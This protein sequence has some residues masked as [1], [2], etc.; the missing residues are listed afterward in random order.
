MNAIT[1][2]YAAHGTKL[3]GVVTTIGAA[4]NGGDHYLTGYLSS[5]Q[6]AIVSLGLTITGALT[7][8]RGFDNTRR[9]RAAAVPVEPPK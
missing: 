8:G 3:L 5:G 9:L 1:R 2:F 6:H 4:C 7:I